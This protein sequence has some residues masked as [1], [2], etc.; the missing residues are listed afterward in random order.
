MKLKIGILGLVIIAAFT[1]SDAAV[2]PPPVIRFQITSPSG[3]CGTAKYEVFNTVTGVQWGCKAGTWTT[4]SGG[5][6]GTAGPTGAT[7]ATGAV[8]ATGA[9]GVAGANG[10]NGATGATGPAGTGGSGSAYTVV[11]FSATPT[12]T[13]T[14][15]TGIQNFFITLTGNVT[16]S[17]LSVTNATTGQDIAFHIC[18]DATGS[19]TFA[20]PSNVTGAGTISATASSCSN[21]V[22]RYDSS[23]ALAFTPMA[24]SGATPGIAFPGSSSG[25][26]IVQ[27]T[28]AASGTITIPA[29]TDTLVGKATTDTLTNKSISGGQITSAVPTATALAAN[30]TNCSAGNYPLGVDASGNAEGCTAAS[31]GSSGPSIGTGYPGE[32]SV[33]TSDTEI[34]GLDIPAGTLTSGGGT[35]SVSIVISVAGFNHTNTQDVSYKIWYGT[36]NFSLGTVLGYL[37]FGGSY[38]LTNN[39]GSTTAQAIA[40]TSATYGLNTCMINP[41]PGAWNTCEPAQNS[42]SGT[43]RLKITGAASIT[44]QAVRMFACSVYVKR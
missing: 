34:C 4:I 43:L 20:W 32:I 6:G 5:G 38:E 8:G 14:T 19:R 27:A 30:G 29:A 13:V 36:S 42:A 17:T 37:V 35:N 40:A 44:T 18:Q 24:V 33:T 41:T 25:T 12:F 7:G 28:A 39:S 3:S 16:S 15:S 10:T 9:T 2:T 22:F 23:N 31:G 11:T 1:V 26:T 21:Q